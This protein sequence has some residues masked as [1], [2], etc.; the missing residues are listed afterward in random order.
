MRIW[1]SRTR[2]LTIDWNRAYL[3]APFIAP[4][5]SMQIHHA[6]RIWYIRPLSLNLRTPAMRHMP[7]HLVQVNGTTLLLL[8]H[9]ACAR[10]DILEFY[11][12]W[13]GSLSPFA[14]VKTY[15][16]S[17][18]R[19]LSN[20]IGQQLSTVCPRWPIRHRNFPLVCMFVNPNAI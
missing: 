5:R 11:V 16:G 1:I 15:D 12:H 19:L 6:R 2:Q 14:H 10:F 18:Y 9:T 3:S 20:H 7:L 4:V 13:L 8:Q 17:I